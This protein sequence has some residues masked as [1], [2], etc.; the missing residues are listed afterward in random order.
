MCGR[1]RSLRCYSPA[2]LRL[3]LEDTGL[4]LREVRPGGHW[5]PDA[6][7]YTPQVPLARAMLQAEGWVE[8][9]EEEVRLTRSRG[10]RLLSFLTPMPTTSSGNFG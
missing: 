9:G 6:R 2:D 8:E 7:V 4:R 5:D 10:S 3:L 1:C